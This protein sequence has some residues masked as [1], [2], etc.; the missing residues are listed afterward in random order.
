MLKAPFQSPT[1]KPKM[2]DVK[3]SKLSLSEKLPET[4]P[5]LKREKKINNNYE[6]EV[7]PNFNIAK[8]FFKPRKTKKNKALQQFVWD[9]LPISNTQKALLL[10]SMMKDKMNIGEKTKPLLTTKD[11]N[12]AKNFKKMVEA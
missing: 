2:T 9:R 12:W 5:E 10:A 1:L 7:P 8:A 11:E 6:Y 3:I 4:S